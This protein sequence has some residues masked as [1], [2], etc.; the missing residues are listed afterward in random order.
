LGV[1]PEHRKQAGGN[2]T[3]AGAVFNEG[4]VLVPKIANVKLLAEPSDAAKVIA[5]LGRGE[6]LVVIGSEK[7]GYINVQG[8]SA[9]GWIKTVLVTK[10]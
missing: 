3:K 10:R 6:E 2:T 9:S 1:R 4:D 7:G 8:A 5:T